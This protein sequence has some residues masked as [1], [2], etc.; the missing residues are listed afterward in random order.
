MFRR[1]H[2]GDDIDPPCYEDIECPSCKDTES[3][4]KEAAEIWEKLVK[5]LYIT[6]EFIP[7]LVHDLM[8]DLGYALGHDLEFYPENLKVMESPEKPKGDKIVPFSFSASSPSY[9][10]E[11]K[12]F[13][14]QYL[15][16]YHPNISGGP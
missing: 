9:L 14:S 3:K 13:N 1:Y 2:P 16:T 5:R 15:T 8:E 7:E 10:D 6:G 11:W 4:Y 12:D